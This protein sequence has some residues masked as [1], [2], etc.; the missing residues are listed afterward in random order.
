MP[1]TVSPGPSSRRSPP[2]SR[3]QAPL[4][5]ATALVLALVVAAPALAGCVG[6]A[7]D[8]AGDAGA[9]DPQADGPGSGSGAGGS[10]GQGGS[11]GSGGDGGDAGDGAGSDGGGGDGD[12]AGA[13]DG[14]GS[15]P[16]ARTPSGALPGHDPVETGE[17][18][19]RFRVEGTA[20]FSTQVPFTAINSGDHDVN[21][22]VLGDEVLVEAALTWDDEMADIDLVL[23]TQADRTV[24]QS[25]NGQVFAN[26]VCSP[27]PTGICAD[28]ANKDDPA[29]WEY[30]TVGPDVLGDVD[31]D[32]G[33]ER[34]RIRVTEYDVW[35][36]DGVAAAYAGQGQGVAWTLEVWVYTVPAEPSHHPAA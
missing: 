17:G 20:D 36:P 21:L 26:Q 18:W 19:A 27:D 5:T 1:G 23:Q 33:G 13:D 7:G 14:D 29:L 4:R 25:S 11:G 2:R 24:N 30:L 22:T 34:W 15:A 16:A 28:E 6:Q 12:G 8:G 9:T 10:G 35:S 32:D 31:P 3:R